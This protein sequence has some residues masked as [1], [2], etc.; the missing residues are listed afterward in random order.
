M[1]GGDHGERKENKEKVDKIPS[2]N[3]EKYPVL[4]PQALLKDQ[5]RY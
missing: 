1:H 3:S 4:H 2:Q 5:I